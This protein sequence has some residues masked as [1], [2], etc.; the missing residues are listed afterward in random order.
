MTVANLYTIYLALLSEVNVQQAGQIRPVEDFTR[1]LNTVSLDM[2]REYTASAEITQLNADTLAPFRVQTNIQIETVPGNRVGRIPNPSNYEAFSSLRILR[3]KGATTCAM[4]T[5]LPLITSKGKC[6]QVQDPDYAVMEQQFAGSNLVESNVNLV[7]NQRWANCLEHAT[8]GPTF[9]KPKATQTNGGFFIAPA[10]LSV[11]ILDYYKT[12]T[13]YV[14][15]YT[16]DPVTDTIIYN[17]SGSQQSEWSE[18][19]QNE[20]LTRLRKKYGV[21]VGDEKQYGFANNDKQQLVN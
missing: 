18:G 10:G 19:M 1:W 12:P 11:V 5:T 21:H 20:I 17:P 14:F 16:I 6:I 3:P 4:D 2:F 8:K 15:A 7:D 13:P 9:D